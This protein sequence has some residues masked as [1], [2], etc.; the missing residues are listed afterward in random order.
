MAAVEAARRYLLG[1][2][3]G[4][5]RVVLERAS[6]ETPGLQVV[7][8]VLAD[9]H[10][11]GGDLTSAAAAMER[12]IEIGPAHAEMYQAAGLYRSMVGDREA[13]IGHWREGAALEPGD[14]RFGLQTASVL[15]GMGRY[16]EA[17]AEAERV[18][19]LDATVGQ[20]H[21]VAGSAL[22]QLGEHTRALG[23]ARDAVAREPGNWAYRL[24]EA[25]ALLG[26]GDA[27]GAVMTLRALPV[28]VRGS[29][30]LLAST[31]ADAL[32][33]IGRVDEAA[34]ALLSASAIDSD[35]S[36]RVRAGAYLVEAGEL[37]RA[38]AVA[39]SLR[40]VDPARAR[41]I[42]EAVLAAGGDAPGGGG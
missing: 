16:E 31:L 24:I 26:V 29:D 41:S 27:E 4:K 25:Q 28:E 19:A 17:A 34:D 37:E 3:V 38:R 14:P 23:Y 6:V 36:L 15:L 5:A 32:E 21:A 20:A 42:R 33:A 9:A 8:L 12:A 10:F 22:V 1:G 35:G 2:E 13:A 40:F 11:D 18:I 7:W 39:D 30:R